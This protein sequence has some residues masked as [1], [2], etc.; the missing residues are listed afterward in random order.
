MFLYSEDV[1][2]VFLAAGTNFLDIV[3]DTSVDLTGCV[4]QG[5]NVVYGDNVWC[6]SAGSETWIRP[7][8]FDHALS[9]RD[10]S[11]TLGFQCISGRIPVLCGLL[12]FCIYRRF[13]AIVLG[14]YPSCTVV[15]PVALTHLSSDVMSM[16]LYSTFSEY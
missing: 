3:P 12:S 10:C 1:D 16:L 9:S 4:G 2:V 7:L 15:A 5:P 11:I 14:Y 8:R 13:F 6:S